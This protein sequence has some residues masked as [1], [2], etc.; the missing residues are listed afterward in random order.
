MQIDLRLEPR[1]IPLLTDLYELTMAASYFD[2]GFNDAAC[3][4][5]SARRLPQGRGFLVAAGLERLLDVLAEFHFEQ[6][7]LDYLRP[8]GSWASRLTSNV[9]GG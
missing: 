4:S 9:R 8:I 7:I 5:M 2:L 3:F 6:P 1:E